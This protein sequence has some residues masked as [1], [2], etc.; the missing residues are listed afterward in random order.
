MH[1][2]SGWHRAGLGDALVGVGVSGFRL[3]SAGLDP[4]WVQVGA[5]YC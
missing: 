5:A 2:R 3:G 1:A 4:A